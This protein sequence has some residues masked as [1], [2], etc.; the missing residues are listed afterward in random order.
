MKVTV[1]YTIYKE[2][3]VEVDEEFECLTENPSLDD[4]SSEALEW[5][6]TERKLLKKVYGLLKEEEEKNLSPELRLVQV[7]ENI[8]YEW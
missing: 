1:G 7:G 8:I 5:H 6:G 2:M 3:E 4:W